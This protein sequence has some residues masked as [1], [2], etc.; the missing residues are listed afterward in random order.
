MKM[1][2]SEVSGLLSGKG[3]RNPRSA[4]KVDASE[5]SGLLSGKQGEIPDLM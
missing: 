4:V 1:D 3:E 2:A 5:V